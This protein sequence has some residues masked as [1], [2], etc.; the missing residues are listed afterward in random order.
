M[1]LVWDRDDLS[2]EMYRKCVEECRKR[3]I[4]SPQDLIHCIIP[5]TDYHEKWDRWCDQI[6][7]LRSKGYTVENRIAA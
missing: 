3:Q 5:E 7:F 1:P 2:W 4:R 6:N